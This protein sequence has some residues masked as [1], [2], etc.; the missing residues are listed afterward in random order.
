MLLH[1]LE[2]EES[3]LWL[4]LLGLTTASL[5]VTQ[6]HT[7]THT[8]HN[9]PTPDLSPQSNTVKTP[10]STT[11]NATAG[12]LPVTPSHLRAYY[13]ETAMLLPTHVVAGLASSSSSSPLSCDMT[14]SP[15]WT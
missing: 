9:T 4:S 11:T 10:V 14:N 5:T 12:G 15:G 8:Q 2:P 13:C 1:L 3:L 7:H 6:P